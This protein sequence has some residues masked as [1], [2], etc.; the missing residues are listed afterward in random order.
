MRSKSN[1]HPINKLVTLIFFLNDEIIWLTRATS[2]SD[3][4]R[5]AEKLLNELRGTSCL[6]NEV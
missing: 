4:M 5:G 3:S 6:K 1:S 2:S